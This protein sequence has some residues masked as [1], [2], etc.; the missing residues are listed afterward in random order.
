ME[1]DHNTSLKRWFA[2]YQFP[3]RG[4]GITTCGVNVDDLK[5]LKCITQSKRA[6]SAWVVNIMKQI[7]KESSVEMPEE[8]KNELVL[9]LAKMAPEI[10]QFCC[11][12]FRPC[13]C[14]N[15]E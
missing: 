1:K 5:E 7:I 14:K 6:P 12:S 13:G 8:S 11:K 15:S 10:C 4:F 3:I 2:D 9:V